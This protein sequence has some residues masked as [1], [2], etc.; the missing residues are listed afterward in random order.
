MKNL[1]K[2][3]NENSHDKLFNNLSPMENFY[4]TSIR[5]YKISW[6][7]RVSDLVSI[8]GKSRSGWNPELNRQLGGPLF[9]ALT[10]FS[11]GDYETTVDLM[12]PIRYDLVKYFTY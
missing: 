12:K 8:S 6:A 1:R 3:L 9:K 4:K 7:D 11:H 5:F 2:L 10:A